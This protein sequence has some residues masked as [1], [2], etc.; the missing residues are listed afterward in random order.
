MANR[1][2]DKTSEPTGQVHADFNE[3]ISHCQAQTER[4]KSTSG[5]YGSFQ[6]A[7][8]ELQETNDLPSLSY[9]PLNYRSYRSFSPLRMSSHL[10]GSSRAREIQVFRTV[11]VA[12]LLHQ[13]HQFLDELPFDENRSISWNLDRLLIHVLTLEMVVKLHELLHHRRLA[14][15]FNGRPK[16]VE[17]IFLI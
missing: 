13:T 15:R 4:L 11:T 5:A 14:G 16:F 3:T 17:E 10:T 9:R 7:I 8:M 1:I 12:E 6:T 2:H